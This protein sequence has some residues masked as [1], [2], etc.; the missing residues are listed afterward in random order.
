[1]KR[2]IEPLSNHDIQDLIVKLE[3]PY[4]VGVF[5]RD[6]LKKQRR[7][8][9][10]LQEC[11]IINHDSSQGQ[12]SHWSALA[13]NHDVAFYFDSFGKLPP[14][15]EVLEYLGPNIRLFYNAKR[16]QN[17]GTAI[18]GHLCLKFLFDFWSS[19]I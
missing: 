4:F 8:G 3:I 19:H 1:M 10:K 9:P 17:Y 11:L 2:S 16:Y 12:G 13:K 14:P 5:M 6:T 18:C 7:N 15:F